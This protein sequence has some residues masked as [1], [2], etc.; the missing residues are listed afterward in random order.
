MDGDARNRPIYGYISK[1]PN[2]LVHGSDMGGY[3]SIIIKYKRANVINRTTV[4]FGDSYNGTAFGSGSR[5]SYVPTPAAHPHFTSAFPGSFSKP[6]RAEQRK[7]WDPLDDLTSSDKPARRGSSGQPYYE[8][9]YHGGVGLA[10]IES[11]R[12]DRKTWES[13]DALREL[14][15][16]SGVHYS[17]Y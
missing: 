8:A 4:T 12:I 2:G 13:N 10:D 15:L 16:K 3:G 14:V 1:D 9:Q 5:S 11:I 6:E 17:V 7:D